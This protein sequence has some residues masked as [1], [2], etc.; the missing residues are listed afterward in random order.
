MPNIEI[1][2]YREIDHET[3]AAYQL[4]DKIQ[5]LLENTPY[6]ESVVITQANTSSVGYQ[7]IAVRYLRIWLSKNDAAHI[8]DLLERLAPLQIRIECVMYAVVLVPGPDND[9]EGSWPLLP[10]PDGWYASS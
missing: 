1:H 2:G 4:Q 5:G 6:A 8:K 10:F 7:N 3:I 9:N